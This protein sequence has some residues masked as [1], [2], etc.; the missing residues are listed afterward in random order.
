MEEPGDV[1][2]GGVDARLLFEGMTTG[3]EPP[4]IPDPGELLPE[5]GGVLPGSLPSLMGMPGEEVGADFEL[6]AVRLCVVLAFI[7]MGCVLSAARDCCD[8]LTGAPGSLEL[9]EERKGEIG[10]DGL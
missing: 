3:D 6:I 7:D 8:V 10:L 5:P 4:P 2:R 9:S 1:E